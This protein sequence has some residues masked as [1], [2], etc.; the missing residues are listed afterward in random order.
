M[1]L[2]T[3]NLTEFH[4]DSHDDCPTD[5]PLCYATTG[6]CKPCSECHYCRDGIDGT[7]G[8]CGDGYPTQENDDCTNN[9]EPVSGNLL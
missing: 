4:C 3:I 8:S 2:S 9:P 5:L 6:S 1:F 7:C